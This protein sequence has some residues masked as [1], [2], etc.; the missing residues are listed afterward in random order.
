M[1]MSLHIQYP[2]T[3]AHSTEKHS[4]DVHQQG[5]TAQSV[6]VEGFCEK[7]STGLLAETALLEEL[8][9]T[10]LQSFPKVAHM[11]SGKLQGSILALLCELSKASH[12]LELGTFTGYS[13]IVM[14]GCQNVRKVVTIERDP[15]AAAIARNFIERSAH[16]HKINLLLGDAS[17]TLASVCAEASRSNAS[18]T[19]SSANAQKE[20]HAAFDLVFLDAGKRDYE[21]QRNL[22]LLHQLIPVGGLV[23]A[24]NVVWAGEVPRYSMAIDNGEPAARAPPSDRQEKVTRALY[25]YVAV[26]GS[27]ERWQ[28]LVLPLRDGLSIARRVK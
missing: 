14:A 9:E 25:D 16:G 12:V 7:F 28:Q 2:R 15:R 6:D 20:Q 19:S 26:T 27:D 18:K 17:E 5:G 10:T 1:R 11:T 4:V 24:D 3:T 13:S 23:V 22:L 21:A 8:E